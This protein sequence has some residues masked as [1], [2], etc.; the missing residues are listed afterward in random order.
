MYCILSKST[1]PYTSQNLDR[2]RQFLYLFN[3]FHFNASIC[4]VCV[5]EDTYILILEGNILES[6]LLISPYKPWVV[7]SIMK[8]S[9]TRERHCYMPLATLTSMEVLRP[10]H[11]LMSAFHDFLCFS[12]PHPPSTIA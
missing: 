4:I 9:E 8:E 7:G 2:M 12:F 10:V 1:K 6:P 5:L 3:R 11:S